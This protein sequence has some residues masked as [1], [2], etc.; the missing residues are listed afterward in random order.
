MKKEIENLYCPGATENLW[1]VI[2][3]LDT[4]N[5]NIFKKSVKETALESLKLMLDQN[6]IYIGNEWVG[7]HHLKRWKLPNT[8]IIEIINKKWTEGIS[9]DNLYILAWIDFEG[10]YLSKLKELG[11]T[12]ITNWEQFV[13]N[14]I[15]DL[16][17][18][19]EE[20]KPK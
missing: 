7:K 5:A 20:N 1:D 14:E 9:F 16:K 12:E 3:H 13:K 8:E 15:G 4:R 11:F 10:W 19:I 18:W 2:C 6:V 17:K